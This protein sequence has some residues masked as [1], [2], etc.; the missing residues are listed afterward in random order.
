MSLRMAPAG[1]CDGRTYRG[2][3]RKASIGAGAMILQVVVHESVES[4]APPEAFVDKP[5]AP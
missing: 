2:G 1:K 4:V 3:V 5:V